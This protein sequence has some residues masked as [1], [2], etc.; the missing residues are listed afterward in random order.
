MLRSL[1]VILAPVV[2]TAHVRNLLVSLLKVIL[3]SLIKVIF[4]LIF[5]I[6]ILVILMFFSNLEDDLMLEVLL[7]VW[8]VWIDD[9]ELVVVGHVVVLVDLL[10]LSLHHESHFLPLNQ[11]LRVLML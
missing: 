8:V 6:L 5:L 4:V 2:I 9:H 11:E 10:L 7:V 3:L 1:H